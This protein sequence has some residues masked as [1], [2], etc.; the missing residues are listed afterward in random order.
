MGAGTRGRPESTALYGLA[1]SSARGRVP[2]G[3]R[4]RGSV[5]TPVRGRGS[6]RRRGSAEHSRR[7]AELSRSRPRGAPRGGLGR[8]D[9]EDARGIFRSTLK[10]AA[11]HSATT[12]ASARGLPEP[13]GGTDDRASPL[14]GTSWRTRRSVSGGSRWRSAAW[15]PR[16][17]PHPDAARPRRRAREGPMRDSPARVDL[18]R[19]N[20]SRHGRVVERL[21]VRNPHVNQSKTQSTRLVAR[22]RK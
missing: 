2:V 15:A 22:R 1:A 9:A 6:R 16:V 12:S 4:G 8:C 17:A 3:V 18:G 14:G 10:S 5:V 21:S 11:A 7:R 20:G 13:P 19:S